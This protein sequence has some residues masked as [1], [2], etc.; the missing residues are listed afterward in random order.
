VISLP[1]STVTLIFHGGGRFAF[2]IASTVRVRES[3]TFG[4]STITA[5]AENS[6]ASAPTT[7]TTTTVVN[8]KTD[9]RVYWLRDGKVWPVRRTVQATDLVATGAVAELLRGPTQREKSDLNAT[10]AI[11]GSVDNAELNIKDGA[12]RAKLSGDLPRAGVCQLVYTLTQFPTVKGVLFE[13]DGEPVDAI[14]GE[15]VLADQ[16]LTRKD[17][18]DLLPAITVATPYAGQTDGSPIHVSG[19]A[20]VFEAN[21]TVRILDARGREIARTFTTATCGTGCRGRFSV[22]V[23]F[24]VSHEQH[25]Y[26]VVSDD[27]AAGTGT[28]PHVVRIPVV[29]EPPSD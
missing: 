29:L 9:V 8:G 13:L 5:S 23:D 2:G 18:A 21:V 16:P 28:P 22:S 4:K 26:I 19:S 14:G 25:G 27:D 24:A 6:A 11:P 17:Y 20:N 7:T 15:G 3:W 1:L 12:A 10:T